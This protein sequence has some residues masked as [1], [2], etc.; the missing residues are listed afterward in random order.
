MMKTM[1]SH[2]P[3]LAKEGAI[4]CTLWCAD[5]PN[6]CPVP[7]DRQPEATT[8]PTADWVGLTEKKEFLDLLARSNKI[9]IAACRRAQNQYWHKTRP[10][11]SLSVAL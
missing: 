2:G 9:G 7:A 1:A 6:T 4:G 5:V 11:G 8:A 3:W 10:T